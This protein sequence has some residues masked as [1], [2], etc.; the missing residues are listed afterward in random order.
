MPRM[1]TTSRRRIARALRPSRNGHRDGAAI[2]GTARLGKRTKE[3]VK[4]LGPPDVAVI[5]HRNLDRIADEELA[6]CGVRDVLNV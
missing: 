5:D 2:E 6:G 1:A 4:G 3:L